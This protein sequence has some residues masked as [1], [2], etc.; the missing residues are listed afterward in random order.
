[1]PLPLPL[2]DPDDGPFGFSFGPEGNEPC[3]PPLP[4]PP[5]LPAMAPETAASRATPTVAAA[6]PSMMAGRFVIIVVTL[7]LRHGNCTMSCD[8]LA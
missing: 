3:V 1:M 6:T 8:V 4:E 5:L 7:L 2:P